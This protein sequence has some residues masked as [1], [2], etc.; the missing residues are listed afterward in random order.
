MDLK[1]DKLILSSKY[2]CRIHRKLNSFIRGKKKRF[3][4]KKFYPYADI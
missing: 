1:L 2:P 3:F 4:A